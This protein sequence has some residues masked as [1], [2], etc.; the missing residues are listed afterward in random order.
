LIHGAIISAS[1]ERPNYGRY[2][3]HI[4]SRLET[5]DLH[6]P[7]IPP[8]G[9]LGWDTFAC[10]VAEKLKVRLVLQE[11]KVFRLEWVD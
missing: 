5:D 8:S 4:V 10:T 3:G 2:I 1:S 7:G 6:A 11:Q 9:K